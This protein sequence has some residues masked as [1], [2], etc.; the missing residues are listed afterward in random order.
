[1]PYG[2]VSGVGQARQAGRLS[3]G[4]ETRKVR[5]VGLEDGVEQRAR[6]VVAGDEGVGEER[7]QPSLPVAVHGRLDGEALVRLDLLDEAEHL[8][9]QG[10][11]TIGARAVRLD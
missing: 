6:D 8:R 1:I 9:R 2:D 11:Q 5:L 3:A 10:G 7:L 4:E